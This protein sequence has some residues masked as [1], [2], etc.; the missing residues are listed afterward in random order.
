MVSEGVKRLIAEYRNL[1][2]TGTFAIKLSTP[3]LLQRLHLPLPVIIIF[4]PTRA[5]FSI[6]VTDAPYSAAV[7]A[8]ISPAA[9]APTTAIFL[10]IALCTLVVVGINA[11]A[12]PNLLELAEGLAH[13]VLLFED[14]RNDQRVYQAERRDE[15]IDD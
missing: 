8:A 5:F 7:P 9:P 3:Q 2:L 12:V 11:V 10:F 13:L 4:R 1:P 15:R 6:R 14:G